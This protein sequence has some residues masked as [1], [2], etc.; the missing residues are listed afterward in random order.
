VY[1]DLALM[2]D[3]VRESGLD[4]RVVRPPRLTNG[5]LTATYRTAYGQ[6]LARGV[7]VSRADVAHFMLRLA[8]DPTAIGHVV[9]VAR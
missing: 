8:E 6:N 3:A 7:S 5:P 2:E 4:W 1:T 9:G